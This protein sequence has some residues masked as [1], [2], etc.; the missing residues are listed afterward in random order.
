MNTTKSSGPDGL[1]PLALKELREVIAKPLATFFNAS[2]QTGIVPDIW[3]R[4]NIVALYKKGDKSNPGNYRP[5]SLSSVVCKL[6]ERLV[7]NEIVDHMT[8]NKLFSKKKTV[9]IYIWKIYNTS[10]P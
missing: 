9:R 5:V 6:M 3:E 8:K 7:R 2:L 4:G 10:A 1:H